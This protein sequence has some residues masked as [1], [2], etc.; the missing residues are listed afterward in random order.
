MPRSLLSITTSQPLTK[1]VPTRDQKCSPITRLP[2]LVAQARWSKKVCICLVSIKG[3][4]QEIKLIIIQIVQDCATFAQCFASS[5][6]AR[7]ARERCSQ[8]KDARTR[9]VQSYHFEYFLITSGH[10]S[11]L[12]KQ[13]W[14]FL[15]KFLMVF[16]KLHEV[17]LIQD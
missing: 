11:C 14:P 10:N 17:D 2:I 12:N 5:P 8:L 13:F 6:V 3:T 15:R 1:N 4:V 9:Q 7:I 16:I